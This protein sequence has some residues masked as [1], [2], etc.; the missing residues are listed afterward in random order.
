M[1]ALLAENLRAAAERKGY[2]LTQ[3]ADFATVSRAQLFN[4]LKCETSPTVEWLTKVAAALE[5]E[6]WQLLAP[7]T[8]APGRVRRTA[9]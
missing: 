2:T 5:A 4:V 1:R 7:R 6:P 9:R 3:L 8:V